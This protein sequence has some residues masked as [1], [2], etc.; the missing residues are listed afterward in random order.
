MQHFIWVYLREELG[1]PSVPHHFEQF[2]SG[3]RIFFQRHH[4][5]PG[6]YGNPYTALVL[7][8]TAEM[9]QA[10]LEQRLIKMPND[11]CIPPNGPLLVVTDHPDMEPPV[12]IQYV[13]L[14]GEKPPERGGG[15][16]PG[17][18]MGSSPTSRREEREGGGA[19]AG[20]RPHGRDRD[21]D[22]RGWG[23]N[24]ERERGENSGCLIWD[25]EAGE[26]VWNPQVP[27]R[28]GMRDE[29]AK[30]KCWMVV[31]GMV[32]RDWDE[33]DM[34]VFLEWACGF[35]HGNRSPLLGILHAESFPPDSLAHIPLLIPAAPESPTKTK[36]MSLCG[37]LQFFFVCC[38]GPGA[39]TWLWS[40]CNRETAD[41]WVTVRLPSRQDIEAVGLRR[42]TD[43]TSLPLCRTFGKIEPEE[44][45]RELAVL[46]Y[47]RYQDD[48][49]SRVMRQRD[50]ER[51]ADHQEAERDRGRE[52]DRGRD[53]GRERERDREREWGRERDRE[54][55][56]GRDWER[57]RDR[58]RS[59][60]REW[61]RDR[62]RERERD[63][64][65]PREHRGS[66]GDPLPSRRES[67]GSAGVAPASSSSVI[68][69][70]FRDHGGE[71]DRMSERFAESGF[72]RQF[73]KR[74]SRPEGDRQG[75]VEETDRPKRERWGGKVDRERE[76]RE[77]VGLSS[78]AEDFHDAST[79]PPVVPSISGFVSSSSLSPQ[80][81]PPAPLPHAL[82]PTENG[83]GRGTAA[84]TAR[85]GGEQGFGLI[86]NNRESTD[87]QAAHQSSDQDQNNSLSFP[88]AGVVAGEDRQEDRTTKAEE[89]GRGEPGPEEIPPHD[90]PAPVHVLPTPSLDHPSPDLPDPQEE[91]N[92]KGKEREK[93]KDGAVTQA[94][95][96]LHLGRKMSLEMGTKLRVVKKRKTMP[97]AQEK[98]EVWKGEDTAVGAEHEAWIA[99]VE[100]R[101]DTQRKA[102]AL[103]SEL[104]AEAGLSEGGGLEEGTGGS[105][106]VDPAGNGGTD[107]EGVKLKIEN[108]ND[109]N[110]DVTKVE[111]EKEYAEIKNWGEKNVE[112]EI[113]EGEET[114]FPPL[115]TQ[116]ERLAL[117]V[118]SLLDLRGA[119]QYEQ[120]EN[121][122]ILAEALASCVIR[123]VRMGVEEGGIGEDEDEDDDMDLG[124]GSE[125]G[126]DDEMEE[127][128]V[129]EDDEEEEGEV[130]DE[131][132]EKHRKKVKAKKE[133]E[134]ANDVPSSFADF[135]PTAS[136][137]IPLHLLRILS[138]RL[139]PPCASPSPR[140]STQNLES[141][142]PPHLSSAASPSPSPMSRHQSPYPFSALHLNSLNG[143]HSHSLANSISLSTKGPPTQTICS[144][145]PR[146]LNFFC[147]EE[148][149]AVKR[150]AAAALAAEKSKILKAE[151]DATEEKRADSPRDI[152]E[153]N[154]DVQMSTPSVSPLS[155]TLGGAGPGL[156]MG[157]PSADPGA[158]S[159]LSVPA[160]SPAH[161]LHE[162]GGMQGGLQ[163]DAL[164]QQK[165]AATGFT[166]FPVP[167][168]TSQRQEQ[169]KQ[170]PPQPPHI[171]SP[172]FQPFPPSSERPF[173]VGSSGMQIVSGG[174]P[175]PHRQSGGG[176]QGGGFRQ[177]HG[178]GG[179]DG[180][181]VTSFSGSGSHPPHSPRD[182]PPPLP[183]SSPVERGNHSSVSAS[184]SRPS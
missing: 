46:H 78:K 84:E 10:L 108:E 41:G 131:E 74:E 120:R 105:A 18:A 24:R 43:R 164:S 49:V 86:V 89:E 25:S 104:L 12:P 151:A 94:A 65:S 20:N 169:Q 144:C 132:D 165:K 35:T 152:A 67:F 91:Q 128:E 23:S 175:L 3:S 157:P 97:V 156:P 38:K 51:G 90:H 183:P 173:F 55:D 139:F 62:E 83:N 141:Q 69:G 172:A 34:E 39:R 134:T 166:P 11:L 56:R 22:S 30:R 59:R 99:S 167:F 177:S 119:R 9:K 118:A 37:L 36:E 40:Q 80:H 92:E 182:S 113:G 57:E 85:G 181:P 178:G 48:I 21:S 52:W 163:S 33:R 79:V 145:D 103:V 44:V 47:D 148:K 150:A 114:K 154:E 168:S 159:P 82:Q 121:P 102:V 68:L 135:F 117:L 15:A 64:P 29:A 32:P 75:T 122:E 100:E 107:S 146:L 8:P 95:P 76:N 143:N 101:E 6:Y 171:P 88:H 54:W 45:G 149:R 126:E 26:E 123:A 158:S 136:L 28:E 87:H 170:K 53:L 93:E 176:R 7:L 174:S 31:G 1:V 124:G 179:K 140:V 4:G 109:E 16:G 5:S 98:K 180:G 73:V 184:F 153:Q 106:P 127:G 19:P 14:P 96:D 63:R 116:E 162:K 112:H 27:P 66:E 111:E 129:I 137:T 13:P 133:I 61:N 17:S 81:P 42:D 155:P 115:P 161:A 71:R 50:R 138:D 125:N 77:T 72:D 2:V 142:Q 58:E 110:P 130:Q 70:P 60:E 160:S 147:K